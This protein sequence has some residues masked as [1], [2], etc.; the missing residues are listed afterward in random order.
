MLFRSGAVPAVRF[1][2][3][4]SRDKIESSGQDIEGDDSDYVG[5]LAITVAVR[6]KARDVF[7]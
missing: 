5:D 7:V 1:I 6:S 4:H 2:W 3:F